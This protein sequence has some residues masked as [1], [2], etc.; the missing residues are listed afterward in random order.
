MCVKTCICFV[1]LHLDLAFATFSV[2]HHNYRQEMVV[3]MVSYPTLPEYDSNIGYFLSPLSD[4][5]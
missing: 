2:D 5:H 1:N 3:L 4:Q